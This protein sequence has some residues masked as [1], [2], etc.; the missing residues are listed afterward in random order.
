MSTLRQALDGVARGSGLVGATDATGDT[1]WSI[2]ERPFAVLDAA[3][4]TAC[5]HL[6]PVLAAAACR[7]P[8]TT[9]SPRGPGWVDLRPVV[10]DA[11]AI[12]R[13][14]AW[15]AAAARRAAD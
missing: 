4:L 9:A 6:D 14:V 7:T 5:F 13:A 15:F 11:H 8:D 3:G 10:V 1:T 2:A 12:D